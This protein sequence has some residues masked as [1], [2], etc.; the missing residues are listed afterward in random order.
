MVLDELSQKMLTDLKRKRGVIKGSLTRIITFVNKFD[1]VEHAVSLLDFRQEELPQINRK[2]D[3]IQCEIELIAVDDMEDAEQ[4]RERFEA[5][6][7]NI[8]SRIQELINAERPTS[9]TGQNVSFGNTS[10]SNRVQLALIP[11]P[12]FN[13]NIQDWPSFY[14]V[15]KALVHHDESLSAAQKFYYLRS[16]LSH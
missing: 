16:C 11:L 5:D 1:P 9:T 15:F 14:D 4:E 3:A 6:Y 10:I 12:K 8:R 7:Y 2:F 13:G